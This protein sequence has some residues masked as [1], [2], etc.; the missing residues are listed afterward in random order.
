MLWMFGLLVLVHA[1]GNGWLSDLFAPPLKVG[2]L[3]SIGCTAE[4]MLAMATSRW[5]A[6]HNLG[7]L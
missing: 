5:S 3:P 7:R 2:I 1:L 4:L 6:G